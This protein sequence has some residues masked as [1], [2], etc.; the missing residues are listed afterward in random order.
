MK[1]DFFFLQCQQVGNKIPNYFFLNEVSEVQPIAF[2][3]Y[4]FYITEG[5]LSQDS[6]LLSPPF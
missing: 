5:V 1:N 6:N 3:S 4:A 2:R